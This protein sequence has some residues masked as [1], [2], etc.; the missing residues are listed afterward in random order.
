MRI[1]KHSLRLCLLLAFAVLATGVTARTDSLRLARERAVDPLD[2]L[3]ASVLLAETLIPAQM[4]SALV[5]LLEA[6]PLA[7]DA[8]GIRK[9]FYHNTFGN[10]YWFLNEPEKAIEQ[11]RHVTAMR[12]T[13]VLLNEMARAANSIGVLFDRIGQTD[14]ARKYL[15]KA[16]EI[17]LER[18]NRFGVTKTLY[19]LG[20]HHYRQDQYE[21]AMRYLLEVADFQES[22]RD[23]FRL[24]HTMTLLGNVYYRLDSTDRAVSNYHQAA[25]F[26]AAIGNES[27]EAYAWNN[28]AAFYCIK[29]DGLEQTLYYANKGLEIAERISDYPALMNLNINIA[30]AH[31]TAGDI[32]KAYSGYLRAYNYFDKVGQPGMRADLL[33]R[34]GRIYIKNEHYH[35][36]RQYLVDGLGIAESINS[37]HNQSKA[38][39]YLASLDSLRGNYRNALYHYQ[40]GS[41][42]LDSI[43]NKETNSRIAELQIIYETEKNRI[44][45]LELLQKERMNRILL[46]SA[47][48]FIAMGGLVV[49]FFIKYQHKRRK[50]AEQQ[51]T[52]RQ[53]EMDK[54][55]LMLETNKQ[56]LTG[57]ALSLV[58]SEDLIIKLRE[59]IQQMLPAAD[60]HTSH[61]LRSVLKQLKASDKT[62]ELWKDFEKRF[63]ELND[64]FIG[65]LIEH[66]PTLTNVE[67]RLCAMLR[68]QL[69]SKDIADL[70]SRSFRTIEYTRS[71]IRQKMGL[72]PGE[73]LTRHILNI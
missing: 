29:D 55:K 54:V 8:D 4:D 52:I 61:Q 40:R 69:S 43:S 30:E 62:H 24:M 67:A 56:E 57:K 17:D 34:L 59:D 9:A 2:R 14:S 58:K 73:N 71:N 13:D 22:E 38:H 3:H 18:N 6:S 41:A 42:L 25:L 53:S 65:K 32:Q 45:I 51:L 46:Q 31:L 7:G 19:D 66:Y 21:L 23:T 39:L 15:K 5:L 20:M 68:L 49:F 64:G 48:A 37:L 27:A 26:A 11:F 72:K 60:H 1:G 70:T 50:V 63:N 33:V 47:A 44:A 12:V 35:Q 10:Y 36:A 28:L 16:L